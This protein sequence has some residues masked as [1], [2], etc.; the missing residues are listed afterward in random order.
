[1]FRNP[2]H[3]RFIQPDQPLD[4]C[5]EKA[6]RNGGTLY[7]CKEI[8]RKIEERDITIWPKSGYEYLPY[9]NK[10]IT[11][12]ADEWFSKHTN[13]KA[14]IDSITEQVWN[15]EELKRIYIVG[16]H[17][18]MSGFKLVTSKCKP[19]SNFSSWTSGINVLK[20]RQGFPPLV[21]ACFTSWGKGP[22]FEVTRTYYV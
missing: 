15:C 16:E 12:D 7:D 2:H 17:K 18:A 9:C 11:I 5:I 8:R 1:M 6:L 10:I 4:N 21:I 13:P 19:Q 22:T 14:I 3:E 20:G